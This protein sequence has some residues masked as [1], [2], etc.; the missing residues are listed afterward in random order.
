VSITAF[1]TNDPEGI[2][3]FKCIQSLAEGTAPETH[4]CDGDITVSPSAVITP[5]NCDDQFGLVRTWTFVDACGNQSAVSQTL[6]V[7]DDT[8]PVLTCA[9]DV[10]I[11]CDEDT[12]PANTGTSTATD[13]CSGATVT[14]DDVS[15]QGMACGAYSYI[16]IRTWTATDDCGNASTCSQTITVED[17]NPPT[18]TCPG[19]VTVEC[20]QPT[21]PGATGNATASGDNCAAD[22]ELT[23]TFIDVSSQ[24]TGCS[25][26]TYTITRTW[27]ASDPCGNTATCIQVISVEDTTPP[28]I[29]CPKH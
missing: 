11:E 10:T 25:N 29:V 9:A 1:I 17:N 18:I 8:G 27:T 22:D 28:V 4:F 6:T 23:V 14:F 21:D 19:D 15:T 7:N 5:G 2:E 13:N 3:P 12:S 24:G 26:D 16:I 20:D